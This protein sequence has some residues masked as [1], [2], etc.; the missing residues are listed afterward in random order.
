[1]TTS[2]KRR[3][4][5]GL[6]GAAI[7][8]VLLVLFVMLTGCAVGRELES[9]SP[10]VGVQLGDPAVIQAASGIGGVVGGLFGGPGGAAAGTALFGGIAT[11]LWGSRQKSEGRHVGWE[12][13]TGKPGAAPVPVGGGAVPAV[14]PVT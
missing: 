1:M 8:I 2:T 9:G 13:A 6:I 10:M 11:L 14:P 12:E 7:L 4:R 3:I 5:D